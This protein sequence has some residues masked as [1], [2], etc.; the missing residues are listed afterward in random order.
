LSDIP[1]DQTAPVTFY[2]VAP[3]QDAESFIYFG[4]DTG[5][6]GLSRSRV[7]DKY[8]VEREYFADILAGFPVISYQLYNIINFFL[9]VFETEQSV[10]LY[11]GITEKVFINGNISDICSDPFK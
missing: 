2:E 1:A 9:D 10:K 6:G 5:Y 3:F 7:S 8:R 11:Q 4:K